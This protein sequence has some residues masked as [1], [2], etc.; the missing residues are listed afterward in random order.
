MLDSRLN[1]QHGF[2]CDDYRWLGLRDHKA[3]IFI[4]GAQVTKAGAFGAPQT[5]LPY[6]FC[7]PLNP[8]KG[9]KSAITVFWSFCRGRNVGHS[10]VTGHNALP[11]ALGPEERQRLNPKGSNII[12]VVFIVFF[13]VCFCYLCF[14]CDRNTANCSIWSS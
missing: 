14:L 12:L 3:C 10:P 9:H 4:R 7:S 6:P 5:G 1:C 2:G 8:Q 11:Q 13:C